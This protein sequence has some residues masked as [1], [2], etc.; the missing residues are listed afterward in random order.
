MASIQDLD[1][2]RVQACLKLGGDRI[3]LLDETQIYPAI[4]RAGYQ[5]QSEKGAKSD[6]R[7]ATLAL[8]LDKVCAA[9]LNPLSDSQLALAP[10]V[11]DWANDRP[12]WAA[13]ELLVEREAFRTPSGGGWVHALCQNGSFN[14]RAIL[15]C[16]EARGLPSIGPGGQAFWKHRD[17]CGLTPIELLWVDG[18]WE[19]RGARAY[20][21]MKPPGEVAVEITA[22]CAD[23]GMD[24][25]DDTPA[26]IGGM[27]GVLDTPAFQP[28]TSRGMLLEL[29]AS[30]RR[31][32]LSGWVNSRPPSEESGQRSL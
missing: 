16:L 3:R 25:F 24:P 14:L 27:L 19:D 4:W 11:V 22:W 20:G 32:R 30:W 7:N 9:G 23:C 5:A 31:N 1:A 15:R 21:T 28:A 17:Q 10:Y 18:G 29:I 12:P 26:L 2:D 8:I 13:L 6:Q